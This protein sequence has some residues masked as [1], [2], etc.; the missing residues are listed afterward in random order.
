MK[1]F[2]ADVRGLLARAEKMH[3]DPADL[4]IVDGAMMP[5][6]D[7]KIGAELAICPNE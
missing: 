4:A 6:R 5:L 7:I 1:F 3:F 2:A